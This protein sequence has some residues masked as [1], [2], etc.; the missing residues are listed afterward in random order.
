MPDNRA[1]LHA[2]EY[3][4]RKQCV[5]FSSSRIAHIGHIEAPGFNDSDISHMIPA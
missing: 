4:L 3:L 1:L 5:V 2:H